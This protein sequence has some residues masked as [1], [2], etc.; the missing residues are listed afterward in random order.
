MKRR[1]VKGNWHEG[2]SGGDG[3]TAKKG[4]S[5]SRLEYLLSTW[6]HMNSVFICWINGERF[7]RAFIISHEYQIPCAFFGDVKHVNR[8]ISGKSVGVVRQNSQ[9]NVD[10]FLF[11][12]WSLFFFCHRVKWIITNEFLNVFSV[13]LCFFSLR[14]LF[15]W[16]VEA[17]FEQT[18]RHRHNV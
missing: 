11:P 7:C 16:H 4:M 1:A 13:S 12:T 3:G 14:V 10:W 9:S 2:G 6:T 17:F 15:S 8:C 5:C 18:K